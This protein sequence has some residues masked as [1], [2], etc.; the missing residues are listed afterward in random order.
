[1]RL[2]ILFFCLVNFLI[3]QKSDLTGGIIAFNKQDIETAK[4]LIDIAYDKYMKKI[5]NG[6]QDKPKIM[7]KFWHY[8]GQIYFQLGDLDIAV[9]SFLEDINLNAKGGFQKK[10]TN[11]LSLCAI[12]CM[13]KANENY[14]KA[15]ELMKTDEIAAK[16]ILTESADLFYQTYDIRKHPSIGIIDTTSLFYSCVLYSDIND[17]KTDLI[18]LEQAEELV[19]LNPKDEQFQIRLLIC[20]EKK[21]DN[22]L[23]LSAINS[24]RSNVPNSIEVIT[25]EVNYYLSTGDAEG[26]KSSINRALLVDPKNPLLYFAL[27]TA[28][29]SLGE[30][31]DA[32]N[33]YLK[34][35]ELNPDYF[36]A[37][38]NL[39][40]MYIDE[41]N[42]LIDKMNKLGSGSSAQKKY[43]SLKKKRDALYAQVIPHLEECV[44]LQPDNITMLNYLK[45][46]YYSVGDV[47]NTKRIGK[48]IDS[49]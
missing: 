13:N 2:T 16:E 28:L 3:A 27:G 8:R 32:K 15:V 20:L 38:N 18:A 44:R 34:A 11:A 1:M 47:K 24:A 19:K 9:Q 25:K 5:A 42:S 12:S 31:E 46:M 49:L 17:P 48:I 6:N 10:S 23:L 41:S 39:A 37:H 29:Q 40:S 30:N 36:D 21:G 26:L 35:I 45:K 43:S 22:K 4:E 7:S 33:A 14:E